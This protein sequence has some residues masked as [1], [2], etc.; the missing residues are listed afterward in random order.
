[1]PEIKT[2]YS[3]VELADILDVSRQAINKRANK[4]G[5]LFSESFNRQGGH[6][7]RYEDLPD[8]VKVA[9]A[10]KLTEAEPKKI[11]DSVRVPGWSNR[12]GL[13]RFQVVTQWRDYRREQ[14]K[15]GKGK[16]EATAAFLLAYNG[17]KLLPDAFA[18]LG[19]TQKSS[20]YR[21]DQLLQ[22]HGD[23][24]TALCDR[25][26]AW[27]KGQKKGLGNITAEAAEAFLAAWLTPNKPS[28]TLAYE[29]MAVV[30][31][32]AG[33]K[34]PS[35]ASVYRFAR[36]FA[37][38]NRDIYLLRRDGEKALNDKAQSY[39]MRNSNQL[40]VGECLF[41]DGH[42]L[43]FECLHPETGRPF[44]PTL[45]LW[46]DW[47]SR[48]PV[49]W[50]I[51]PTEDTVAIASAL[52][53]AIINL[54]KYP[55]V[56]Y[57]DNGRA[58]KSKYFTDEVNLEEFSGLYAR[59]GI[60]LQLAQ[61]Y[62]GQSKVVE[63]FFRTFNE[64]F[65]RLL[66]SYTGRDITDKPAWRQRN[67]KYHQRRHEKRAGIPTLRQAME[68]FRAY[69]E[70][71]ADKPHPTLNG[72]SRGQIFQA[73]A[74][75]GVDVAELNRHFLWVKK[76][77]PQR[78]GFT[79]AGVRYEADSLY[80]LNTEI[81]IRFSWADL[82]EVHLYDQDGESLGKAYPQ[83]EVHPLA[84]ELG[85]EHDRAMLAYQLRRKARLKKK[86][87]DAC[88]RLDQDL[89][90][91][92]GLSALSYLPGIEAAVNEAEAEEERD[93]ALLESHQ[94][95]RLAIQKEKAREEARRLEQEAEAEKA[96]SG[97]EYVYSSM[98]PEPG[99]VLPP[100]PVKEPEPGYNDLSEE[101]RAKREAVFDN[102][103][104][105]A[106]PRPELVRPPFFPNEF[107]KY[108]W[109]FNAR[110]HGVDLS[111]ADLMFMEGYEASDEYRDC[112]GP[113]YEALKKAYGLKWKGKC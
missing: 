93:I 52:R 25:R 85:D 64:Q 39:L 91:A 9:T 48:M 97:P 92:P 47:K 43:N 29:V 74:G 54:G 87:M 71:Y 112:T 14:A 99:S 65:S 62:H 66:P 76:V 33:V 5:W 44:R 49:G 10:R 90:K 88:R 110:M 70:W 86:T 103:V 15:E 37:D 73:G 26:G 72:Q 34:I 59:L 61:P 8:D 96:D 38:Q 18:T 84:A 109:M 20:L 41:A 51:M 106:G 63:R 6:I 2:N 69:V 100:P 1:M 79:L 3:A 104:T 108:D 60:S 81:L 7:Y 50:E 89:S 102:A 45:I 35:Q 82:S 42:T 98:V 113:R 28:V 40:E 58:F 53:M 22:E 75:S 27:T 17:G 56:A 77:R 23:D 105:D 95:L 12:I 46:F 13:A 83:V 68:A 30:L 80:G 32:S 11:L 67:E 16:T 19:E 111:P 4:E 94:Q 78:T 31:K 101:E 57:L 36:R 21:W 107:E 24:Y 55:K